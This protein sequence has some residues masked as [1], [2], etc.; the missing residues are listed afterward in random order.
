ML[1]EI[2][3]FEFQM[4]L[5]KYQK[6]FIFLHLFPIFNICLSDEEFLRF[7]QACVVLPGSNKNITVGFVPH[8]STQLFLCLG[9]RLQI[10]FAFWIGT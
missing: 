7:E 9:K 3:Y 2:F 8:R 1:D 5:L 4:S 10:P 6:Y